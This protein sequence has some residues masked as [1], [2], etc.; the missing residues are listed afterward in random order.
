[1]SDL[2]YA[3]DVLPILANH[4]RESSVKAAPLKWICILDVMM[5]SFSP[6]VT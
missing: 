3:S 6:F 5:M 4:I 1:M 2:Q